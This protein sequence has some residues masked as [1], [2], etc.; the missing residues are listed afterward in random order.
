MTDELWGV[1]SSD[2]A[3]G[4]LAGVSVGFVAGVAL[5]DAVDL[6]LHRFGRS[7]VKGSRMIR[8]TVTRINPRVVA[9]WALIVGVAVNSVLG[10]LLI[11]QRAVTQEN[12]DRTRQL[13]GQLVNLTTCLATYQRDFTDVY[14][15]R[16]AAAGDAS[17]ALDRLVFA[18]DAGDPDRFER[19]LDNYVDVRGEQDAERADN[20]LPEPPT[21]LCGVPRGGDVR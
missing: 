6:W 11:Q 19:A 9:L 15:A 16:A 13:A 4:V 12:T 2:L 5:D 18:V 10:L 7:T 8:S 21:E 14:T 1:L 3:L 20:P 17:R